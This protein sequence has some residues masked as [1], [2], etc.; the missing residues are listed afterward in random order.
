[1]KKLG[2]MEKSFYVVLHICVTFTFDAIAG[3]GSP[4]SCAGLD[5]DVPAYNVCS[6]FKKMITPDTVDLF[7]YISS[8]TVNDVSCLC[9]LTVS[10][11]QWI[12]IV[13]NT[14]DV[15]FAN[16]SYSEC[17]WSMKVRVRSTNETSTS[18]MNCSNQQFRI[19]MGRRDAIIT[20]SFRLFGFVT[21]NQ[22]VRLNISNRPAVGFSGVLECVRVVDPLF[23]ATFPNVTSHIS[24]KSDGNS[25]SEISSIN[26]GLAAGIIA[27]V[28]CSVLVVIGITVFFTRRRTQKTTQILEEQR[29]EQSGYDTLLRNATPDTSTYSV[30][31]NDAASVQKSSVSV[32][33]IYGNISHNNSMVFAMGDIIEGYLIPSRS[34]KPDKNSDVKVDDAAI[35]QIQ[36]R[37]TIEG[38]HGLVFENQGPNK[39]I[40]IEDTSINHKSI[41][42]LCHSVLDFRKASDMEIEKDSPM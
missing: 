39:S 32:S 14:Y 17:F 34:A 8:Q 21:E 41:R 25:D 18:V 19:A 28:S 26:A 7:Y 29:P 16:N 13:Y 11:E 35:P 9:Y 2:S 12:E 20:I 40:P 27:I 36:T 30:I 15:A 22:C 3:V 31:E 38:N 6:G 37:D 4:H 24:K 5:T 1:M 42:Y 23:G 33:S 10:S